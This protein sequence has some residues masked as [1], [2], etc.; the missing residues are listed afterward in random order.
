MY[1]WFGI[2]MATVAV[3]LGIVSISIFV[4]MLDWERESAFDW[5]KTCPRDGSLKFCTSS[6]SSGELRQSRLVVYG[7]Q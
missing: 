5:G 4:Q 6:K 1:W 7:F 2:W 3:V